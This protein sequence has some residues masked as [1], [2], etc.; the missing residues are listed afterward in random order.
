VLLSDVVQASARVAA[1]GSRLEKVAHLADL[2]RR[3][4]PAETTILIPYLSGSLPQGRVG[5]GWAA[6]QAAMAGGAADRPSLDLREVDA[7]FGRIATV[8]GKGAARAKAQLLADLFSR[9]TDDER[10]FLARL[11]MGELRQGAEEGVM[12]EAVARAA[13]VSPDAVRRAVMA[14]GDL[15]TAAR[16]ALADGEAGLR[17]LAVRLFRPVQ[18]MLAQAAADPDEALDQLGEAALEW[19]LD[20]ARIQVHKAGDEV[21]VFS[22]QLREVT[23]AVPEVVELVRSLSPRELILDGE[24]IAL[25]PDGTPHPFQV[26]MRRFGRKL[27]VD[28]LRADLPLT[29]FGFDLLYL[30]GAPLLDQPYTRRIAALQDALPPGVVVP[31]T[32]TADREAARAFLAEARRRG[33]EGIMAKRLDAPYAAGRRGSAWLKVKPAATLDLVVLAAEWGHGRRR[34][35][36]SNLHLGARDPATGGFVMLGKTF[37]GLT[38]EMLTWQTERL[39]A[40]EVA[41]D[42]YTVYVRPELVVE[43]AFNDVQASPQYPGGVALRFARVKRYRPEKPARE[44]DTIAEVR[45]LQAGVAE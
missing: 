36:L 15:V 3:G 12:L 45:R 40:L 19:K 13:D 4:S 37:K 35:W 10:Q 43:V 22:R 16:A 21:R 23:A 24:V 17:G 1:T 44:A 29:P 11:V 27:E 18:P 6:L 28:R 39:L 38:D 2:I 34:G 32:V 8:S 7:A 20:G 9:G 41:R 31:R 26:T 5:L 42:A 14:A 30:D 25:R 33:H